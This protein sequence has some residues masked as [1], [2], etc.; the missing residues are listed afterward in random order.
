MGKALLRHRL[1]AARKGY[2]LHGK[3]HNGKPSNPRHPFIGC[4]KMVHT[5]KDLPMP[6]VYCPCINN[7][8][9]ISGS[10]AMAKHF[11][12]RAQQYSGQKKIAFA[13]PIFSAY[14]TKHPT[15]SLRAKRSEE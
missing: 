13:N 9:L 4:R 6:I 5:V 11:R 12:H 15:L 7:V 1:P 2:H 3:S 8:H 14:C 10:Y